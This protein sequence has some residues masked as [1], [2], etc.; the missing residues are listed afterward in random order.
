L[1]PAAAGEDT[2]GAFDLGLIWSLAFPRPWLLA[3][4]LSP[5]TLPA[6]L[7]AC[8][9]AGVDLNSGVESAPGVKDADKLRRAFALLAKAPRT[10]DQR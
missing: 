3:G 7:S 2:A 8:R 10:K 4:G 9:P 5:E 1:T 6:A